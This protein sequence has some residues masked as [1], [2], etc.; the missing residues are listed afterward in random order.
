ML[1]ALLHSGRTGMPVWVSPS[2][3]L[4][5]P[6]LHAPLL[7]A[8]AFCTPAGGFNGVTSPFFL[9]FLHP[10]A[11]TVEETAMVGGVFFA[12]PEMQVSR[13]P[14]EPCTDLG[15]QMQEGCAPWCCGLECRRCGVA[16]QGGVLPGGGSLR[17]RL[18]QL[19]PAPPTTQPHPS[20]MLRPAPSPLVP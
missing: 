1:A 10:E 15:G 8:P 3:S 12:N 2:A 16:Q 5:P 18:R 7:L 20:P 4:P 13:L 9:S 17:K 19:A 14:A 6:P 11:A